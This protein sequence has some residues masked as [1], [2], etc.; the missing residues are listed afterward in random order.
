MITKRL[1][2]P[3]RIRRIPQHF[4]WID[5]R[6]VRDKHIC[7]LSSSALAL[8][9]FLLTVSDAEG[10]SYYSRNGIERYLGFDRTELELSRTELVRHGLIAYARPLYQ[11]LSLPGTIGSQV[12]IVQP[13]TRSH[14]SD[15]TVE[16]LGHVLRHLAGGV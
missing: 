14:Q 16:S 6:L 13:V 9:L 5:H 1:L 12:P 3:E 11:V 2:C 7:G 10:I 4:S 15:G 8:Y